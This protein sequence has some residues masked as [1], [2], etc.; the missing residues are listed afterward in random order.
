MWI[1]KGK[2]IEVKLFFLKKSPKMGKFLKYIL[3]KK[4]NNPKIGKGKRPL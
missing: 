4:L 3:V 1:E 2:L